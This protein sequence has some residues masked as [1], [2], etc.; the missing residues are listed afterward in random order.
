MPCTPVFLCFLLN[1]IKLSFGNNLEIGIQLTPK[2][3]NTVHKSLKPDWCFSYC[4]WEHLFCRVCAPASAGSG[5]SCNAMAAATRW[6]LQY[7]CVRTAPQAF[8]RIAD[9]FGADSF[10]TRVSIHVQQHKR[11]GSKSRGTPSA[12]SRG[13]RRRHR[14][15]SHSLASQC[16]SCCQHVDGVWLQACPTG[17]RPCTTVAAPSICC[18]TACCSASCVASTAL[19]RV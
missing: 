2:K 12:F 1:I 13:R 4:S 6:Q 8:E 5:G 10:T 7:S 11:T 17:P 3:R 19:Q 16:A 18:A 14:R 15:R 9:Y